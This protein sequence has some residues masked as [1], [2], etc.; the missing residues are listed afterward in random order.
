MGGPSLG[1][2][3]SSQASRLWVGPCGAGAEF[4]AHVF[5]VGDLVP[6]LWICHL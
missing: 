1:E 6:L 2:S 4:G 5:Y 3:G